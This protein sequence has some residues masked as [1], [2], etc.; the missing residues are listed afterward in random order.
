MNILFHITVTKKYV[1]IEP[2]ISIIN[3]VFS[4]QL[5][6]IRF[7]LQKNNFKKENKAV[8]WKVSF[9]LCIFWLKSKWSNVIHILEKTSFKECWTTHKNFNPFVYGT[10]LYNN[11]FE[12]IYLAITNEVNKYGRN[13]S[14]I[15]YNTLYEPRSI[16]KFFM[17]DVFVLKYGKFTL[18]EP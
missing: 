17:K 15:L 3:N 12:N 5:N 13:Q 1:M 6:G 2:L 4:N 16:T 8:L 9:S 10:C 7:F 18:I 11:Y 14:R